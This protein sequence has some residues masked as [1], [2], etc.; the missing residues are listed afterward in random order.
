MN[1]TI[2]EIAEKYMRRVGTVY[3]WKNTRFKDSFPKHVAMRQTGPK[4]YAEVF[5]EQ[6][7]DLWM[8][9]HTPFDWQVGRATKDGSSRPDSAQASGPG[10]S[11]DSPPA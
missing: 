9:E 1:L 7:I 6:D 10:K 11:S 3:Y 5:D 8:K 4:S 2:K